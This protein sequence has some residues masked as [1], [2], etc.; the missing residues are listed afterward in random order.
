MLAAEQAR[1]KALIE[2]DIAALRGILSPDLV[3]THTNGKTETCD[4][5]LA[6]LQGQM[7]YLKLDRRETAVRL[8]GN[9]AVM[10][11]TAETT[12]QIGD[13]APMSITN[14]ALQVWVEGEGGWRMVAFQGTRIC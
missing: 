4:E 13:G 11:G 12:G 2:G 10:T 14:K 8:Y 3:H 1:C 7:R 5:Y 6:L 9:V